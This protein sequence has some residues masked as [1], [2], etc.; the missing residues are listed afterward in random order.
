MDITTLLDL[1]EDIIIFDTEYTTWDGALERDWSGS[2]EHRELVQLA[3]AV[4]NLKEKR[5]TKTLLLLVKPRI[6]YTLS[7]YFIH[8]THVTQAEVDASGVDFLDAYQQ[9][10]SWVDN[11]TC[12]SYANSTKKMADGDILQENII[13]YG[14]PDILP[15][16]QFQNIQPI[17]QEAGVPVSDYN[18]GKLHK[19]FNIPVSGNEH[20]AMHDVNSLAQSLFTLYK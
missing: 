20:D 13:L 5:V 4:V 7:D 8:L 16:T 18:S 9:F 3:A 14:L 12:F 17:F 6:N 10:I 19:Y 2:G 1:H 11:K 15:I